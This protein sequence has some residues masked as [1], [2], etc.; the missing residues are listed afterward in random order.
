MPLIKAPEDIGL[1]PHGWIQIRQKY[2]FLRA[3]DIIVLKGTLGKAL[4]EKNFTIHHG[5]NSVIAHRLPLV[6][7]NRR[8]V[9]IIDLDKII[10]NAFFGVKKRYK[11][12]RYVDNRHP[13]G[14]WKNH[15]ERIEIWRL[16]IGA[17]GIQ[18]ND[19]KKRSLPL[20]AYHSQPLPLP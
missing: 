20:N 10:S 19:Q 1:I 12:F 15:A 16:G 8:G 18:N 3:G 11:I 17:I 4:E 2:T 14:Y 6:D 13:L 5:M 7:D 9:G